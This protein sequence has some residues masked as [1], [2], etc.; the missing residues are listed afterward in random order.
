MTGVQAK[1]CLGCPH[2]VDF[3][4]KEVCSQLVGLSVEDKEKR[5]ADLFKHCIKYVPPGA[6]GQYKKKPKLGNKPAVPRRKLY[7]IS[8]LSDL[9]RSYGFKPGT[10]LLC[11]GIEDTLK[12]DDFV[13]DSEQRQENPKAEWWQYKSNQDGSKEVV[14]LPSYNEMQEIWDRGSK[15]EEEEQYES[16]ISQG[17]LDLGD[18]PTNNIEEREKNTSKIKAKRKQEELKTTIDNDYIAEDKKH[19]REDKGMS[20]S[21]FFNARITSQKLISEVKYGRFAC[22]EYKKFCEGVFSFHGISDHHKY[23]FMDALIKHDYEAR[24]VTD[25]M[26]WEEEDRKRMLLEELFLDMKSGL[27]GREAFSLFQTRLINLSLTCGV[28]EYEK[29]RDE[30]LLHWGEFFYTGR[31]KYE[32]PIQED[33]KNRRDCLYPHGVSFFDA[34]DNVWIPYLLDDGD[35]SPGA[36][37]HLLKDELM[38][39]AYLSNKTKNWDQALSDAYKDIKEKARNVLYLTDEGKSLSERVRLWDVWLGGRMDVEK[40]KDDA[41]RVIAERMQ[42]FEGRMADM[43]HEQGKSVSSISRDLQKARE[44]TGYVPEA[45]RMAPQRPA[46]PVKPKPII[47]HKATIRQIP[48]SYTMWLSFGKVPEKAWFERKYG[49]W[50]PRCKKSLFKSTY[51]GGKDGTS[52]IKG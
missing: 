43:A 29:V 20:A 15:D 25:E 9:R 27:L 4:S 50:E 13:Y 45:P 47:C 36:R 19:R 21:A 26:R 14:K 2:R 8:N 34:E 12:E 52:N 23:K 31:H 42:L 46:E 38:L 17:R 41:L 6:R 40:V 33:L 7:P 3:Y 49:S 39:C 48:S 28:K 10:Y 44:S 5:I 1:S 32:R 16:D 22:H 51:T 37:E 24:F 35:F 30:D 18:K 11:Q